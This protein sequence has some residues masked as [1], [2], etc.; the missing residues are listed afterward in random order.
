MPLSNL[1]KI[2]N[3]THD[4]E[5]E[6]V[7]TKRYLNGDGTINNRVDFQKASK[8]FKNI[9]EKSINNPNRRASYAK[10]Y[11]AHIYENNTNLNLKNKQEAN[12][13]YQE[14]IEDENPKALYYLYKKT[15]NNDPS[16]AEEYKQKAI[17]KF[18][19]NIKKY[20]DPEDMFD[21]S[22]LITNMQESLDFL[23]QSAML[24]NMDALYEYN[25]DILSKYN[26]GTGFTLKV[27]G[28][29][30][31]SSRD[32]IFM[33]A[34]RGNVRAMR[35]AAN[36]L[37]KEGNTQEAIKFLRIACNRGDIKSRYELGKMILTDDGI[38]V[39]KE[40]LTYLTQLADSTNPKIADEA[41]FVLAQYYEKTN[42]KGL[43][44]RYYIELMNN[45]NDPESYIVLLII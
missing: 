9:I 32:A 27:Y 33:A 18:Q 15:I 14:A 30:M 41:R 5:Y 23:R 11:L 20:Q 24:G 28:I 22:R 13:L 38:Q 3:E 16:L 44:R 4:I 2:V 31:I 26:K 34:N 42:N 12:R 43:T 39:K 1:E 17:E 21:C 6:Y 7:L 37:T 8:Y 25:K 40:G 10:Y 35:A 29:G 45:S 36:L 19:E